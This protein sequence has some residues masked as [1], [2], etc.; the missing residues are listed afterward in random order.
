MVAG[1]IWV[2]QDYQL[3]VADFTIP[4]MIVTVCVGLLMVSNVRYNSFK[5]LDLKSRVPFVSMLAVVLVFVFISFDPPLVLFTVFLAYALSGPILTLK[6]I[7]KRRA[8]K[9]SSRG[10][11]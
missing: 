3:D 11:D 4:A 9:Q 7:R 10:E 6:D 2:I 8:K 5:S 1:L